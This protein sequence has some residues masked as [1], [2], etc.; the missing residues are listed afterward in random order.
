MIKV[1]S[2]RGATS[3]TPTPSKY[4]AKEWKSTHFWKMEWVWTFKYIFF[5]LSNLTTVDL[6]YKKLELF[7]HLRCFFVFVF[8]LQKNACPFTYYCDFIDIHKHFYLQWLFVY[9]DRLKYWWNHRNVWALYYMRK[10]AYQ[11]SKFFW[12]HFCC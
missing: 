5:N 8:C 4:P 10:Y 1:H 7:L 3:W 11:K 6:L 2:Q 9:I 12:S